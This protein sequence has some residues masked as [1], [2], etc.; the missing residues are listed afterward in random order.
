MARLPIDGLLPTLR[1]LAGRYLD[2]PIPPVALR[3]QRLDAPRVADVESAARA[4]AAR[5]AVQS[6]RAPG[7]VAVGVG[8]RG[9]A[10]LEAIVRGTI[11]GLRESGWDPFIVPAM[12]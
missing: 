12:G 10:N 4:A 3:R 9:I 5:V 6:G 11:S 7:T 2:V 1:D 8:S